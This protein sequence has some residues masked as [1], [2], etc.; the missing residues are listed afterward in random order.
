RAGVAQ[1]RTLELFGPPRRTISIHT[2][3]LGDSGGAVA[4]LEDVTERLRL[5]AVRRDFVANISHELRTPVGALAILAETLEAEDDP[6]TVD[7]LAQRLHSEAHRVGRLI[8]DL[9]ELTRI[10]GSELRSQ[11]R[12]VAADLILEAA[13]RLRPLAAEKGISVEL[14][15]PP[16]RLLFVGDR[17]QVASALGNLLQNAVRYS[18][19][20]ATVEVWTSRSNDQVEF[21]VV[22][23]GIGIPANQVDRIFERFYRVDR[24][25][26]RETGGTGLG[27]SIVRHVVDNHRGSIAVESVEGVGSTFTMR[28]PTAPIGHAHSL[29]EAG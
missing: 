16:E 13:E 22:D 21:K 10:E 18:E 19:P 4:L 7:R 8:D 25:R 24:A 15:E 5:E 17:R 23:H 1:R 9:L 14:H 29:Q 6:E 12:L 2:I 28:L 26:T 3:A 27:L 11:E 20:G